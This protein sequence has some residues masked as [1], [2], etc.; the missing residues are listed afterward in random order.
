MSNVVAQPFH[1]DSLRTGLATAIGAGHGTMAFILEKS[2]L[3]VCSKA[4]TGMYLCPYESSG[5][6]KGVEGTGVVGY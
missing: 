1:T 4:W 6:A 2:K 3:N 5:A